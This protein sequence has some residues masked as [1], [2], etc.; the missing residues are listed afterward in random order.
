MEKQRTNS[1]NKFCRRLL[2]GIL[3]LVL[4]N[5]FY[6]EELTPEHINNL[7]IIP[8]TT[9][10]LYSDAEIHFEVFVPSTRSYQIDFVK[11]QN[12]DN[13]TY[14]SVEKVESMTSMEGT[15]IEMVVVFDN[16][17]DYT[18][19]ALN[20]RIAGKS[21]KIPFEAINVK[22]NPAK[23]KPIILIKLKDG[24]TFSSSENYNQ[25]P[26][27]TVKAGEKIYFTT[28][29]QYVLQLMN[30][31]ADLPKDSLFYKTKSIESE[32]K[33]YHE[34]DTLGTIFNVSEYCWTPLIPGKVSF[35]EISMNVTTYTGSKTE[36]KMSSF[37]VEV[38]E[39]DDTEKKSE[40]N[41]FETA[42]AI[43][44]INT[45]TSEIQR[46]SITEDQCQ[47]LADLRSKEKHSLFGSAK[48]DRKN[49]E[50]TLGLPSSESEFSQ[51]L[52]YIYLVLTVI[53]AVVL[54][55]L[56]IKKRRIL[57]I[58]FSIAL[59]AFGILLIIS[60]SR[61]TDSYAI[62]KGCTIQSIPEMK[63]DS[64]SELPAGTRVSITAKSS[65]WIYVELGETCG[66]CHE[67]EVIFIK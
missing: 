63:V 37:Y 32:S 59:V 67:D 52:F 23:Q 8:S 57:I 31:R 11:P 17:G 51:P 33:Q 53:M 42:F 22:V 36:V 40:E 15:N 2:T 19:P 6:A 54:I 55:I 12:T 14:K 26:K 5:S 46:N 34:K 1:I 58:I 18:L 60:I 44:T 29:M 7:I 16:P 66:W 28:Q 27:L 25:K 24:T 56:I 64:K 3:S 45:E 9:S 21:Y 48:K 49:Y 38:L 10:E 13:Y 35:P 39:A 47:K 65:E 50:S 61:I 43:E 62:S 4:C 41:P 30:E 20:T